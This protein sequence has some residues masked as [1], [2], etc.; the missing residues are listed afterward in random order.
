[1]FKFR[2]RYFF[3]LGPLVLLLSRI[4]LCNRLFCAL[5]KYLSSLYKK[6]GSQVAKGSSVLERDASPTILKRKEIFQ[7]CDTMSKS[8]N[9]TFIVYIH[10]LIIDLALN[11]PNI[12]EYPLLAVTFV[13]L[14]CN[15]QGKLQG[16]DSELNIQC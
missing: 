12:L 7:I 2:S 9:H 14:I 8:I 15:V 10:M 16:T 4:F 13:A 11:C 1:M 5:I 3:D 6:T